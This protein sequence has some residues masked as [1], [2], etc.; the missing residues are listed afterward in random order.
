[1]PEAQLDRFLFKI[2]V[3]YPS[4]EEEI[5]VLEL[6]D[7]GVINR[8]QELDP[9]LSVEALRQLREQVS[10][11]L[12]DSKIKSFIVNIV[13]AT[14]KSGWLYLGASPRASIALMNGAK[15][16][17]AIQGRDFVVPDDV[18]YLVVPVLRHRVQ[19][20]S[21]KELEGVTVDQVIQQIVSKIE[22]PR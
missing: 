4:V 21:E 19:L 3:T 20:S 6:H 12:V 13:N 18:L 17:A 2:N 1:M 8:W 22:V 7:R 16:Y 10:L 9:V 11:I 5:E 15:A 14:R